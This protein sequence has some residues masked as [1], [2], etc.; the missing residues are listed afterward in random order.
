VVFPTLRP[1]SVP[2]PVP[3]RGLTAEA[4]AQILAD[5]ANPRIYEAEDPYERANAGRFRLTIAY[6][7]QSTGVISS[8]SLGAFGLREGSERITLGDRVLT[9]GIDYEIDYD[10]GQVVLRDADALFT[11]DPEATVRATWEQQSLFQ[12][13]P[14][15]LF[16]FRTHTGFGDAG[17]F[18]VLGLYRSE[19]S[20]VRRPVLG[21]EPGAALLG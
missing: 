19:R 21:T 14:T 4:A 13:S 16:G 17:S 20:V 8:F 6:R 1:F 5:D 3:S 15:Q 11:T 10:V 2:P 9:R 12:V 18:D 7:L